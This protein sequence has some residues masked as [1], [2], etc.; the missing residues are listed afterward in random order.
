LLPLPLLSA[1]CFVLSVKWLFD[2]ETL[3]KKLSLLKRYAMAAPFEA[4]FEAQTKGATTDIMTVHYRDEEAIYIQALE[5][6]VTVIF[7]TVFQEETDQ[8][9]GRVFLQV[10]NP[11]LFS[12][13][14]FF[15]IS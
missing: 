6:R 12:C 2:L 5:D 9:L 14:Y 15:G 4:A 3:I 11:V 8:I 7:S 10:C 1:F 13:I